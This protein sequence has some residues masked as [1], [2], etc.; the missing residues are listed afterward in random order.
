[1]FN[2]FSCSVKLF[3]RSVKI[4]DQAGDGVWG[5]IYSFF[6][7]STGLLLEMRKLLSITHPDIRRM[8]TASARMKNQGESA[9]FSEKFLSHADAANQAPTFPMMIAGMLSFM[10]SATYIPIISLTVAPLILRTAISLLLRCD[11]SRTYPMSPKRAMMIETRQPMMT[12]F[13][14]LLSL[15]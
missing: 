9:I 4:P 13:L 10:I 6:S 3:Y 5:G 1:M 7:D 15:E 8:I 12:V 11:S 2:I 14:I